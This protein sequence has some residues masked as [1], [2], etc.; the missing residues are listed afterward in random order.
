MLKQINK[1]LHNEFAANASLHGIKIPL[2]QTSET[3]S[4][5]EL[6][7]DEIA[8]MNKALAETKLSKAKEHMRLHG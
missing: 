3:I 8:L 6:S 4:Q 5:P 2:Q 7:E 1:R